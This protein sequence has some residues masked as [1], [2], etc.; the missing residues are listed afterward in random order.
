MSGLVLGA[1]VMLVAFPAQGHANI[2]PVYFD[3]QAACEAA[4]EWRNGSTNR[5]P[6]E[7]RWFRCF[8]T[9]AR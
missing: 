4:A 9:G 8:S 3:S 2:P 6:P 7:N 1:W 5:N